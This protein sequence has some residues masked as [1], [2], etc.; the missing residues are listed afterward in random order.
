MNVGKGDQLF[1][2]R[3]PAGWVLSPYDPTVAEQV[4]RG[5]T[6]MKRYRDTF[7]ELAR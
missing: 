6:L 2:S 1:V 5:R 4:E 3:S 7:R